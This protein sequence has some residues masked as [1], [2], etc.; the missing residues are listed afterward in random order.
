MIARIEQITTDPAG[1][2]ALHVSYHENGQ[3]VNAQRFTLNAPVSRLVAYRNADGL[4]ERL[5]GVAIPEN[6]TT[7]EQTLAEQLGIRQEVI[8]TPPSAIVDFVQSSI[9]GWAN[10][11]RRAVAL[12]QQAQ[13][14]TDAQLVAMASGRA[15]HW[16]QVHQVATANG[17][18]ADASKAAERLTLALSAASNATIARQ[19]ALAEIATQLAVLTPETQWPAGGIDP[20]GYLQMPELVGLVGTEWEC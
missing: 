17:D 13:S 11:H 20:R 15:A 6:P 12:Q 7:E 5:D 14:A 4:L 18:T 3:Q 2:L 19:L 16:S 10:V 1:N 8:A 9:T